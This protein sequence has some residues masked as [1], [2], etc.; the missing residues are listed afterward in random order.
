[1]Q[2]KSR[3]AIQLEHAK[4]SYLSF[5]S[6]LYP[7]WKEQTTINKLNLLNKLQA[8]KEEAEK[9]RLVSFFFFVRFSLRRINFFFQN[10]QEIFTSFKI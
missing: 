3:A 1:M 9:R 4:K 10:Y 8:E 2:G 5:S 6:K 7:T